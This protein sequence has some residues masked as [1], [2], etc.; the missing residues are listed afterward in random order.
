M[1]SNANRIR[2]LTFLVLPLLVV[3]V[4]NS[5]AQK[6]EKNYSHYNLVISVNDSKIFTDSLPK[7]SFDFGYSAMLEYETFFNDKY[8]LIGSAGVSYLKSSTDK[9]SLSLSLLNADFRLVP[10]YSFNG[11]VSVIAGPTVFYTIESK[12]KTSYID[13]SWSVV[14]YT[15]NF[16]FGGLV[17][18]D[19]YL[20][21]WS[22]L[23]S[24]ALIRNSSIS[25]EIA[26]V[27]IPSL[28][29]K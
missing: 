4:N 7:L 18:L 17:G 3:S 6:S 9:K 27:I 25:F 26:W 22:S 23:R 16:Q 29:K 8:S 1:E 20:N 2:R 14:E 15:E 11:R 24:V 5:F 19:F 12:V 21:D 10:K 28:V 13:N